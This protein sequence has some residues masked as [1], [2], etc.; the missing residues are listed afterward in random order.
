MLSIAAFETLKN[1]VICTD[2]M[3]LLKSLPSTSVDAVITDPPYGN[4]DLEFDKPIDLPEFWVEVQRV[5]KSP[6]SPV[7]IFSQQPFTADLIISNRDS[8]RM[9]IVYEKAMATGFLNAKSHPL[10]CH[11]LIEIFSLKRAYYNPVFE[12]SY[13]K[14]ASI[15][16]R[17]GR[18]DHYEMHRRAPYTDD[19]KRY[20]RSVWKFAQRDTAFEQTKSNHPTEKP[21]ALMMRLVETFC[22]VGGLV[23]DPYA[24]SDSTL[25]AARRLQREFIGCDKDR[26]WARNAASRV[27][28]PQT[29]IMFLAAMESA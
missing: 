7:V 5:L 28:V 27:V 21:V 19:G 13:Q 15:Q 26:I 10:R 17:E 1:R 24:G 2:A 20:P 29:D 16:N 14:V 25:V 11:E 12:E 23:L 22:P 4:T 3:T 6:H 8:W 18:A 9:E